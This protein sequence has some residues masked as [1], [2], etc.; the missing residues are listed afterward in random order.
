MLSMQLHSARCRDV[1]QLPVRRAPARVRSTTAASPLALGRRPLDGELLLALQSTAGNAAVELLVQ[2][3]PVSQPG[4]AVERE[5]SEVADEVMHSPPCAQC[6][7]IGGGSCDSAPAGSGEPEEEVGV[8]AV[9]ASPLGSRLE[10]LGPHREAALTAS[11]GAGEALP[12]EVRGFMEP[13]FGRRF[14]D[15][16]VHTDGLA[17][18][19]N[20]EL[21]AEA[22]TAGSD[23]YFRGGAYSPGSDGG[24]RLLAHELAHVVQ[25]QRTP[26]ALSI[27]R[28]SLKGFPPAKETAM[29]A[30]IPR[31]QAGVMRCRPKAT[32]VA[33]AI[34][35]KTYVYKPNLGLCG[36]TFPLSGRIKI[37]SSAFLPATCCDL[38]ATIAHE[39][40]HTCFYTEGAALRLECSCFGCSCPR[41]R[42]PHPAPAP[43]P[44]PPSPTPPR[45]PGPPAPPAPH[46]VTFSTS[47][48]FE[49]GKDRLR[50]DAQAALL[51]ELGD[52]P[53]RAD[54]SQPFSVEGHT[55]SKGSETFNKGLSI[56]RARAVSE[57]LERIYPNLKDHTSI[58]GFGEDRPIAPNR[59]PNG[60]DNPEGRRRN[61]RVEVRFSTL[62]P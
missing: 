12:S 42:P 43:G 34:V 44:R 39:A 19:L 16:R 55:D 54:L 2:R 27:S 47:T 26:G 49:F 23:I 56:R 1:E 48:L 17:D 52:R 8:Q 3:M 32:C 28:F 62:Q 58:E 9:L 29:L 35:N 57:L 36:W 15:V 60:K 41:P 50:T 25:Q 21:G 10:P 18:T 61:R 11:L 40:S 24:R 33:A 45:P 53:V 22:F 59:L 14:G 30:A 38:E 37:G 5:A 31:A 4:D 51:A 46:H 13:R 20:R 6:K 7:A